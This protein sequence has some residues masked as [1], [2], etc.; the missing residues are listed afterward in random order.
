VE[1]GV[2][3]SAVLPD[4]LQAQGR[5]PALARAEGERLVGDAEIEMLVT[6][7]KENDAVGAQNCLGHLPR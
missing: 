2:I 1:D 3:H 6:Q 7:L 5:G 4:E